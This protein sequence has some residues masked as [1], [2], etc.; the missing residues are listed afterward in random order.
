MGLLGFGRRCPFVNVIVLCKQRHRNQPHWDYHRR[1]TLQLQ[2]RGL[3]TVAVDIL[4]AQSLLDDTCHC[5][6]Y[7]KKLYRTDFPL[8]TRPSELSALTR[9]C[10]LPDP[11]LTK[12]KEAQKRSALRAR[13]VMAPHWEAFS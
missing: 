2:G 10:S 5:Y 1:E 9:I 11:C 3:F 13:H 8:V 6:F 7:T 12:A 4:F